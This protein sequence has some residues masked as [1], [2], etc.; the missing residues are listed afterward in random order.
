MY[1]VPYKSDENVL[2]VGEGNF[3]FAK[4]LTT[5]WKENKVIEAARK[6]KELLDFNASFPPTAVAG[7]SLTI[8]TLT[9]AAAALETTV[10]ATATVTSATSA[11][12]TDLSGPVETQDPAFIAGNLIAT[13]FDSAE[14]I[15]KKYT[16]VRLTKLFT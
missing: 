15:N 1:K 6:A 7:S 12:P 13:S 11:A 2:L 10:T 8:G 4:A 3:S 14:Q 5:V 9:T 16:E